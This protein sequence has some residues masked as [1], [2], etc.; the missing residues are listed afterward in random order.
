[1]ANGERKKKK[2]HHPQQV[3]ALWNSCL[4]RRLHHPHLL[5]VSD[6]LHRFI[7]TDRRT[8]GR[9]DDQGEHSALVSVN[10]VREV[11]AFR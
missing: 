2:G 9:H 7:R 6:G 11:I 4:E 8:G 5:F 3:M 1:M 10:H